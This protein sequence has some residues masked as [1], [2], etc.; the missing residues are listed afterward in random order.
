[1]ANFGAHGGC[2]K[3]KFW[4]H[5]NYVDHASGYHV[6]STAITGY[7]T[8]TPGSNIRDICGIADTNVD[9]PPVLFRLRLIDEGEPGSSDNF[10]IRL[11]N[12]YHV[13][14]KL[15]GAGFHGGG[16]VE[17]HGANPSTTAPNPIPDELTMCG[18]LDA[19]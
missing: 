11:S 17:L 7:L 8:P 9:E 13:P 6:D 10:G 12:G 19:P 5:V 14:P 15:L 16:N 3:G 2:K 18:G 4:G 1:M